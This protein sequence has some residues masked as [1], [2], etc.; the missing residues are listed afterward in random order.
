MTEIYDYFRLLFARIGI[1]H[2]PKCGRVIKEQSV[3]QILDTILSWPDDTRI[4]ILAPV[5]RAMKGEHKKIL[6]DALKQGFTRARIDGVMVDL[7][8]APALE[9]QKSIP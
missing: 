2:C 6:E 8:E 4:Q 3:D 7:E 1:P 5:V 9:K